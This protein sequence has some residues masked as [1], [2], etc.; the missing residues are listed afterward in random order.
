MLR[1]TM[2]L[3]FSSIS[4]FTIALPLNHRNI[5]PKSSFTF[6]IWQNK[7]WMWFGTGKCCYSSSHNLMVVWSLSQCCSYANTF[8]SD[9]QN[10]FAEAP[11]QHSWSKLPFPEFDLQQ[12]IRS[13]LLIKSSCIT[14]LIVSRWVMSKC[15]FV[16][17]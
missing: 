13:G 17:H 16:W 2:T 14:T 3:I 7:G 8:S 4:S 1:T 6:F 9:L 15:A 5:A 12:R 11:K 10:I